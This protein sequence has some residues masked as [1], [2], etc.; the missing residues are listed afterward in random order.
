MGFNWGGAGSGAMSGASTGA[1]FGPWGAAAG[2]V[3]GG[4]M[5]GFSDDGSEAYKK[6]Q[7]QLDKYYAQAREA[8]NQGQGYLQP[9]N[10]YG[11]NA[12]GNY[13]GA[14]NK[15]LDPAALEGEWIKS[16]SESPSAKNA[17]AMAQE[18][19]LDAASSLGLMGS[20]TALNAIQSGTTQIG[21]DDRQNYLNDLMQKYMAGTGIAGNIFGTGANAANNMSSNAMNFAKMGM[22][23]G[24]NSAQMAF[25]QQA[26]PGSMMQNMMGA[27]PGFASM[28]KENAK[29]WSF[30]GK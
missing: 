1:A 16:Y 15:L 11:Q 6:A 18:H 8:Y 23:M 20:N 27:A 4:L 29:G 30:G 24:Q 26:A 3:L 10:Q 14:M 7:E 25:G 2:G 22:D 19:G 5:G 9:Y 12:Y 17:Q 21:L 13:S 28:L